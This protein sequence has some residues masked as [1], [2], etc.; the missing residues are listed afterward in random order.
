M[1]GFT[2]SAPTFASDDAVAVRRLLGDI[3]D[4]DVAAGAGAVLDHHVLAEQLA[5]R[6]ADDA[7]RGVGAAAGLEADHGGDRLLPATA[8]TTLALNASPMMAKPIL[9]LIRIFIS[10]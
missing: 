9:I 3:V 6:R 7:R 8:R 2:V 10:L 1:C 5:E 4:G